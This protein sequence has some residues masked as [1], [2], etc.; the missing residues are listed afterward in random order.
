MIDENQK[1]KTF[2][3]ISSFEKRGEVKRWDGGNNDLALSQEYAD[4]GQYS[5]KAILYPAKYSGVSMAHPP[6]DWRG[7]SNFEF[8]IFNPSKKNMMIVLKILDWDHTFV[9]SDRFNKNIRL[10]PGRNRISIFLQEI[11]SAP[12]KRKMRMDQIG[13]ISFFIKDLKEEQI[14]FF[15]NIR[16]SG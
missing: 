1:R 15:D 14:L 13:Q 8:T 9:Y 6:R 7:F 11:E 10:A 3:I 12:A 5:L 4:E 2:P 16:L